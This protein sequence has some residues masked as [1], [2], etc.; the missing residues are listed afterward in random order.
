MRYVNA[1]LA[2]ALIAGCSAVDLCKVEK[3]MQTKTGN[4]NLA[5]LVMANNLDYVSSGA[6][7][8]KTVDFATTRLTNAAPKDR[9][10]LEAALN[11]Q[12]RTL[13]WK[14]ISGKDVAELE[15]K[16]K[17]LRGQLHESSVA[18]REAALVALHNVKAMLLKASKAVGGMSA[19]GAKGGA[20]VSRARGA[21]LAATA[22]EKRL[23]A[24]DLKANDE[25]L[26]EEET[27]LADQDA[28]KAEEA[29]AAMRRSILWK[30]ISGKDVAELEAKVK[31]LRG[32]LH[33]SSVANREATLVALHNVKAMLLKASKAV[34]GKSAG[35]AKGGASVSRS[36]GAE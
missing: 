35:G 4:L 33:E 19:G 18:N 11:W 28:V 1:M 16:V 26:E 27:Q 6:V 12:R 23:K 30:C 5:K 36:R 34:G 2:A 13:Y 10:S 29:A 24:D 14:S 15:A 22:M 20:S 9:A 21:E 32:Q 7:S 31:F 17:F 3:M 8:N 25:D